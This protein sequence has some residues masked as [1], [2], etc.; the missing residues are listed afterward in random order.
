MIRIAKIILIALIGLQGLFY[1]LNNIANWAAAK[2]FVAGVLPMPDHQA[3]PEAFG[4]AITSPGLQLVALVIIIALELTIP[5]LAGKGVWDMWGARKQDAQA[6]Q[7]SKAFGLM[8]CAMTLFV[9]FGLF[10]VIGEAYFQMWQTTLGG[11]AANGAFQ[12]AA[13]GALIAIFVN[14]TDA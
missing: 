4:P 9:W 5:V 2:G 3:Y 6:F 12:Y 1:A 10:K 8:A 7:A 14:Q 13:L 11:A